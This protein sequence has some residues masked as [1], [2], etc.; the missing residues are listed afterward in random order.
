MAQ[1]TFAGIFRCQ[2][3][4]RYIPEKTRVLLSTVKHFNEQYVP[5][6]YNNR[7]NPN[8]ENLQGLR[9]R[10]KTMELSGVYHYKDTNES[11]RVDL[12]IKQCPMLGEAGVDISKSAQCRKDDKSKYINGKDFATRLRSQFGGKFDKQVWKSIENGLFACGYNG[13]HEETGDLSRRRDKRKEM[14]VK[15]FNATNPSDPW[16]QGLNTSNSW[17]TH[18][19]QKMIQGIE[20]ER[21]A[22]EKA[23][24]KIV[25]KDEANQDE[26]VPTSSEQPISE[27]MIDSGLSSIPEKNESSIVPNNPAILAS[28][29]KPFLATSK[30]DT[31]FR[32]STL[33]TPMLQIRAR[34]HENAAFN[35]GLHNKQR[36]YKKSLEQYYFESGI[37]PMK[38]AD[39]AAQSLKSLSISS[40][41]ILKDQISFKHWTSDLNMPLES[42]EAQM[43]EIKKVKTPL[44]NI[45][46]NRGARLKLKIKTKKSNHH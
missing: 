25:T 19:A 11:A 34:T 23:Y 43:R 46:Q 21:L 22:M 10:T 9:S 8:A 30:S 37:H 45:V 20:D 6:P 16:K 44:D 27:A 26:P 33:I 12:A 38:T 5:E 18:T 24:C 35:S 28:Q 36:I 13:G 7:N 29:L 15:E 2:L 41:R 40:A 14:S 31:R 42:M 1:S 17:R 32:N 3:F 4:Q 39:R